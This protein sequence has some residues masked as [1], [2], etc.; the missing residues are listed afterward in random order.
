M[1]SLRVSVITTSTL[2]VLY[3]RITVTNQYLPR[4][5]TMLGCPDQ[6]YGRSKAG[7]LRARQ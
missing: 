2:L 7:Q 6:H 5:L 1:A 3:T 4:L